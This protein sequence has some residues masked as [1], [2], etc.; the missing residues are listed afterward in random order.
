M[1][2]SKEQLKQIIKEELEAVLSEEGVIEEKKLALSKEQLTGY[3]QIAHGYD[4]RLAKI[5]RQY[6]ESVEA[7]LAAGYEA[8][9]KESGTAL[10]TE[11][12]IEAVIKELGIQD[13][14]PSGEDYAIYILKG[15][16]VDYIKRRGSPTSSDSLN[17]LR[18][19]MQ[20]M[21]LYAAQTA[22]S[23]K[24]SMLQRAKKFIGLEQ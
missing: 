2:L 24:P 4:A 12:D 13:M 3:A 14:I 23:L 1:K 10:N 5:P 17:T 18:Q 6:V 8:F 9:S 21:G 15:M 11:D 20:Q 22:K 19:H 16:I 7:A